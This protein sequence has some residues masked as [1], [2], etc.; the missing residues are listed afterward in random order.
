VLRR[1]SIHLI[2]WWTVQHL[3]ALI[4]RLLSVLL[5]KS[6]QRKH[7]LSQEPLHCYLQFPPWW[8]AFSIPSLGRKGLWGRLEEGRKISRQTNERCQLLSG[9]PTAGSMKYQRTENQPKRADSRSYHGGK[10]KQHVSS[11]VL[12]YQ[13]IHHQLKLLLMFRLSE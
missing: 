13:T 12:F 10:R 1:L 11:S 4:N 7:L 3:N 5:F 6:V 8:N 2:H 9:S